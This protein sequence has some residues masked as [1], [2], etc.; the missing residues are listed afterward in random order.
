MRSSMVLWRALLLVSLLLLALGGRASAASGLDDLFAQDRRVAVVA[1]RLLGANAPLCPSQMPLTGMILHSRDQYGGSWADPLFTQGDVAIAQILPGSVAAMMGLRA[2][3]GVMTIAGQRPV[4]GGSTLREAALALLTK[5]WRSG[6]PLQLEIM[7]D[8]APRIVM[9]R[10]AP[11]CRAVVEV[12]T[13]GDLSARTDGH[14]I[15]VPRRLAEAATDP[16][17]AVI[18]AHEIAHVILR[19]RLRLEA[20]GIDKGLLGELGRNRRLMR[21]AEEEADRLSVHLLA[22]AGYD[23]ASAATFWRSPLGRRVGGGLL[24]HRAYPSPARRAELLEGEVAGH[25]DA[26]ARFHA[27]DHLV[28]L[29][30]QAMGQEH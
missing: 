1:E 12:S 14:V 28:T 6:E 19:H 25:L 8:N 7:R 20:A 2:G 15:Q 24:R 26:T 11:A 3:D 22:N 23:P 13:G 5:E 17:L 30:D 16:D 9:L 4:A 27:A 29:R 18:V 10:P 21:Q